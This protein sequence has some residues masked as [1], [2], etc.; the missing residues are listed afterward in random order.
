MK[1][2]AESKS[3]IKY[4]CIGRTKVVYN[5]ALLYLS[6]ISHRGWRVGGDRSTQRR[7]VGRRAVV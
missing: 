2:S 6:T 4:Q 7:I 5:T 1:E 3:H